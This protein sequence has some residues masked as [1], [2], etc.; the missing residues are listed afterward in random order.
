MI[1]L[2]PLKQFTYPIHADCI[3][4]DSFQGKKIFEIAEL[5]LYEG[6]KPRKL[7]ELFDIKETPDEPN[8]IL[9]EGD[10]E[11]VRRVG[12]G[13][14]NGE[15]VINGKAGMHLGSKMAG[16]KIIVNGDAG[17][18]TGSEMKKGL[19]EIHGN[20]GDYLASPYRGI[21][22]GMKGGTI[23]VDGDVGSDA[24]E[25]MKDGLIKIYG[26]ADQFLGLRMSGGTIYVDKDVGPR[27]GASMTGGKIIV[28]G[29]IKD[30]MPTFT[31]DSIK[32]KV[33]VD[34]TLKA[35]GPLYVFLG[36]LPG[37]KTGKI[38]ALK[39]NNP[40]LKNYEKFL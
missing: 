16:G 33:K 37:H 6:N 13:M 40:Q 7:S 10:I 19:I 2:R 1:I 14:K 35:D 8:K 12:M 38:F 5:Q 36:D 34:D 11:K 25:D 28:K 30:L 26:N 9:I 15:I 31:I 20:A 27:A 24:A 18:W 29:K 21:S 39:S 23:I 3:S 32:P 22:V 17:N 4:P